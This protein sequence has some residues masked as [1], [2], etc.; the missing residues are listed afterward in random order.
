M[1]PC[2]T[3]SLVAKNVH[4]VLMALTNSMQKPDIPANESDRLVALD[5]YKILD[6]LPE[7]VYDD[8]TQLAADICGTPIALISLV[9]KDR[10]WF[11]SRVGIDATETPRD[12]SLLA[13]ANRRKSL[14]KSLNSLFKQ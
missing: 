6:T 3:Y 2:Y 5:R 14:Y 7:Q 10:Q 9:D 12:I 8:L 11:K 1:F 13:I 4:T